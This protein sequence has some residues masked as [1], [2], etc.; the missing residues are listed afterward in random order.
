MQCALLL[1]FKQPV[2]AAPCRFVD[3]DTQGNNCD[4]A[5]SKPS[6]QPQPGRT[7]FTADWVPTAIGA[8]PAPNGGVLCPATQPPWSAY[9]QPAFGY[10]TLTLLSATT[11]T[12]EAYDVDPGAP[13][14][15]VDAVTIT[16]NSG[17][18]ACRAKRARV[19]IL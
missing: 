15:P 11:A 16:R 13:T 3:T 8:N 6:Y 10:G 9:R 17:S 2:P 14:G 18:A 12:W 5:S 1:A 19:R 7:Y 4:P